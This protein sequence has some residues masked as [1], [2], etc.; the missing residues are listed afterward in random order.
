MSINVVDASGTVASF[1]VSG[2]YRIINQ[3]GVVDIVD[4]SGIVQIEIVDA[5]GVVDPSGSFT[6]TRSGN[7][8]TLTDLSTS[9][10]T[11]YDISSVVPNVLPT[12]GPLVGVFYTITAQGGF[13]ISQKFPIIKLTTVNPINKF[14]V[15][16]TLQITLSAELFNVKLGTYTSTYNGSIYN[17]WSNDVISLTSS[18][19]LN[20]I[21][22]SKQI[23][24]LG[25]YTT[26][27]SDFIQYVDQYFSIAASSIFSTV[28]NFNYNN[29][30]FDANAF[31]TLINEPLALSGTI[32]IYNINSLLQYAVDT[33]V[34][35]NRSGVNGNSIA[36]GFAP[37]DL[38]LVPSGSSIT[39]DLQ[40]DL[41]SANVYSYGLNQVSSN[42]IRY[43]NNNFRVSTTA[44]M[45][46]IK[47]VVTAPL[48]IELV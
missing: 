1:D 29:G 21:K 23:I 5:S 48:V 31:I 42:S 10:V 7:T 35:G 44:D 4:A 8:V 37:G 6:I 16:N 18:E 14:D 30:I 17:R 12:S 3:G 20:N 39:L 41:G 45:N 9:L 2:D 27:Y 43:N 13:N 38:I 26:L 46:E 24:S 47:R 33:N 11:I 40:I 28:Q 15:T 36:D 34:F 19:L 32:T 22:F 25:T